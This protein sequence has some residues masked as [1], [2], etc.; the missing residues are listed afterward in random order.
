MEQYRPSE[1]LARHV[2]ALFFPM[3]SINDTDEAD[4]PSPREGSEGCEDFLNPR[5]R[6]YYLCSLERAS[7]PVPFPAR[8]PPP[9]LNYPCRLACACPSRATNPRTMAEVKQQA[10]QLHDMALH[11]P[12]N[13]FAKWALDYM[14][15]VGGDMKC[16]TRCVELA[17]RLRDDDL[18]THLM[19]V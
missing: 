14:T 6:A 15:D 10:Q 5:L 17:V 13:V 11:A 1:A 4:K 12:L 2:R 8:P 19:L 9:S 7:R 18:R 16:V 3:A